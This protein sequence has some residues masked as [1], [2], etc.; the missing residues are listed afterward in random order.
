MIIKHIEDCPVIDQGAL[1]NQ[2]KSVALEDKL[3]TL[4]QQ[5]GVKFHDTNHRFI[6]EPM[7]ALTGV[8]GIPLHLHDRQGQGEIALALAP[9][10]SFDLKDLKAATHLTMGMSAFCSYLNPKNIEP[11][12][13]CGVSFHHGHTSI[14]HT[15]V[16]N[17]LVL[18]HS[19]GVENEFNSQRDL[20]HIS[21]LT[22]ARTQAQK[23]PPLVVLDPGH[24]PLYQQ[25]LDHTLDVLN[26][27]PDTLQ[28]RTQLEGRNLLFPAAK[29]S[30]MMITASLRNLQKLMS[31]IHDSGK[32]EEY[33]RILIKMNQAL[34]TIWDDLFMP[35]DQ[36]AAA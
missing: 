5:G 31:G 23:N 21:R 19:C 32:E 30:M 10:R 15:V 11:D 29:G 16:V 33:K 7:V 20:I 27:S 36:R 34:S 14:A 24:L 12:A 18:G 28:E 26:Q 6:A 8:G 3:T 9:E 17:L 13:M 35:T 2:I 22:V 25:I 1:W 4:L